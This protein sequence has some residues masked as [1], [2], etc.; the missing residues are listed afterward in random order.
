MS[1]PNSA[2]TEHD[3]TVDSPGPCPACETP[4]PRAYYADNQ[5]TLYRCRGCGLIFLDPL[6]DPA[7]VTALYDNAYGD[8][9]TGYFAKARRKRARARRLMPKLRRRARGPDF[10]DIGCNGGFLVEAAREFGFTATG[11]D[12]DPVSIAYARQHFGQNR[13]LAGTLDA[14]PGEE[15]FDVITC[16]E[17]IE[18]VP[19]VKRFAA[20]VF[21]RLRPG[22]L[23]YL[24]TPDIGHWRRPDR[25]TDWDAYC[26][27]AHCL[28]FDRNSIDRLLTACGFVSIKH[29]FAFKPGIRLFA[30]KVAQPRGG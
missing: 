1:S 7:T 28:Y 30:R 5:G 18:H 19:A 25:L 20:E 24:T 9:T 6:P 2:E 22:G 11:I 17:V 10:L 8:A 15:R 26:P 29:R 16:A 4:D 21:Q 12:M 14:V 23:L 13:F 27:P 3:V